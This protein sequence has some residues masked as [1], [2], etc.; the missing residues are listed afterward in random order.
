MNV[1]RVRLVDKVYGREYSHYVVADDLQEAKKYLAEQYSLALLSDQ[2]TV[3]E[4]IQFTLAKG[5][6][7]LAPKD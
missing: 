6:V 7:I 3:V 4:A 1:L 5:T 2:M